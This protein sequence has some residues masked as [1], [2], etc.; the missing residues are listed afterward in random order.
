MGLSVRFFAIYFV[1]VEVAF[2][3][4]SAAIGTAIFRRRSGDRM[5][6]LVSLVLVT[7]GAVFT[8]P[9]PLLD[10]S[11]LWTV[12]A[13]ALS[14]IGSALL[15]LF[16]YLFPDGRFVP[17]WTRWLALMWMGLMAPSVFFRGALIFVFGHPLV[18]GPLGTAFAA[19]TLLPLAYRYRHASSPTQRQQIKWVVFGIAAALGSSC[20]LLLLDPIV[21]SGVLASLL[22]NTLFFLFVLLIPISIAAAILRYHLYDIDFL[23]N[24]TLVY[25]SL[26]AVLALV[27]FSGVTILQG[28]L[29]SLTGQEFTL[30]IVASTLA[31]AAL[32]NPLRRRIQ[33]VIDRRFYRKK[34]DAAKTLEAFTIRLKYKTDLD[35]LNAELV[36]VVKETMHPAHISLW[37]RPE[38][39]AKASV[40]TGV[41][42]SPGSRE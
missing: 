19:T 2:T 11:L 18:Y 28:V 39:R 1:A 21:P 14:F 35:A 33:T 10:L 12:S 17:R 16:L 31:I 6:L 4:V 8:V 37:L 32:F 36:G 7:F 40:Q 15:I 3:A 41:P 20:V 22:G 13:E 26:T 25:G 30:S 5:A 24:R 23:I 9:Y 38:N 42:Y 27:Y 29:R 34:Y